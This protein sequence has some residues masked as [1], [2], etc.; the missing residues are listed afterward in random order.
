M[1]YIYTA[2]QTFQRLIDSKTVYCFHAATKKREV[3][4]IE[5]DFQV[6]D[7]PHAIGL[8]HLKDIHIPRG[9]SRMLDSIL[10]ETPLI[11]DEYLQKSSF[12]RK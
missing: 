2:A 9:K 7:F 11:T 8:Q 3:H 1:D 12:Y 6:K 10:S 5:L 4:Y